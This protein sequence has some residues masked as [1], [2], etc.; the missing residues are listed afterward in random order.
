MLK[1][2][3]K[4]FDSLEDKVRGRLSHWPISYA[5]I[6]GAG[7]V[8]FWRGIWHTA[9]FLMEKFFSAAESQSIGLASK[10]WWDGPLSLGVGI[11]ILL[12]TGALVSSF[13]GNEIIISGLKG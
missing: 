2:V 11:L 9:D 4:F 10:L 8:L 1:K 13:I 7:V 6:C 5:F 12:A 3:F